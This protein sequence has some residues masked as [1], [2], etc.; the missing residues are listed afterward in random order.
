MQRIGD[1]Y[2]VTDP[3]GNAVNAATITVVDSASQVALGSVYTSA[4]SFTAPPSS[5]NPFTTDVLGRWRIALPDGRYDFVI[6]GST[7]PT[8]TIP[9]VGVFDNTV[10]YPSPMLGT[11]TSVGLTLPASTFGATAAVTGAGVLNPPFVTQTANTGFRGPAAGGAATPT[12]RADVLADLPAFGGAAGGYG[13]GAL[14]PVITVNAQ[15]IP[16]AF[17]T[18]TNTPAWTAITGK[19]ATTIALAPTDGVAC[20]FRQTASVTVTNTLVETTL[21]GAGAGSASIAAN[22]LKVG[23][24]IRFKIAGYYQTGSASSVR[25][26]LYGDPASAT[27][28]LD[29]TDTVQTFTS[30]AASLPFM[31][32]VVYTVRT[33][34]SPGTGIGQF[35]FDGS[36]GSTDTGITMP[37]V[38]IT[39]N[40]TPDT[41]VINLLNLTIQWG[42]ATANQ[43]ITV[44]NLQIFVEG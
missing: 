1:E 26:R 25:F 43:T 16:T 41:A 10:T 40:T 31:M 9:S 13:T 22:Q 30:T 34:G 19:P 29:S 42:T 32:E 21:M 27:L 38:A 17:T 36:N 7:F 8:Y 3:N 12:W 28:L 24:T 11:V 6:S 15:G 23:T 33:T 37:S 44:T 20:V 5:P 4:G 14:I 2:Q 35:L 18:T 39:G